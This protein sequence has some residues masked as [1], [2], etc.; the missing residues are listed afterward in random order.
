M[1][2]PPTE[3]LDPNIPMWTE[4]LGQPVFAVPPPPAT[5]EKP[6]SSLGVNLGSAGQVLCPF[7]QSAHCRAQFL[8]LEGAL[9]GMEGQIPHGGQRGAVSP[10]VRPT[11]WEHRKP[12]SPWAALSLRGPGCLL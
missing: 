12:K 3:E 1:I 8:P 11:S 4:R 9:R 6:S 7:G 5:K 2:N 10:E